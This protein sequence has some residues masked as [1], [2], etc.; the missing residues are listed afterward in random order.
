MNKVRAYSVQSLRY[1][2][3]D[4]S[5]RLWG[6]YGRRYPG[7]GGTRDTNGS[8]FVNDPRRGLTTLRIGWA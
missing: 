4:E 2:R 8:V 6:L 7:I 5:A 1:S 3:A